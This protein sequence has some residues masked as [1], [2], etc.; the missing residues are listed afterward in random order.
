M[1]DFKHLQEHRI[2]FPAYSF[3]GTA[4]EAAALSAEHQDQIHFLGA[5]ATTF[6]DQYLEASY[7][8][9]GAMSTRNPTPFRT[10][11]FQNI[12]TFS[13]E[14][15][16]ALKKWLYRRGIPF[17]HYVLLLGNEEAVL[18]TWK[19]VMKYAADIFLHSDQ[20]VFDETLNWGLFYYHHL[21]FTFGKNRVFDPEEESQ[22]MY[23]LHEM[24]RQ[25]P[26]LQFPY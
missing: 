25:Y 11:Y 4:A 5:A 1:I 26:F 7:M 3:L 8:M 14:S 16:A 18:L 2:D 20:L 9:H 17:R 21:P 15:E 12:E 22:R 10:G 6:V 24:R 23:A 13:P 19:M